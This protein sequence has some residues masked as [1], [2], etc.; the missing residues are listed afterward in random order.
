MKILLES[1]HESCQIFIFLLLL[2]IG[3]LLDEFILSFLTQRVDLFPAFSFHLV[4]ELPLFLRKFIIGRPYDV[5]RMD[6]R[7]IR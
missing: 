2:Q 1:R 6:F 3:K 4:E 7:R 5:L